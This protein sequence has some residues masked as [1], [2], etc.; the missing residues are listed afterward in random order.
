MSPARGRRW[1]QCRRTV[2]PSNSWISNDKGPVARVMV[3]EASL[4][5]MAG[6]TRTRNHRQRKLETLCVGLCCASGAPAASGSFL[7]GLVGLDPGRNVK[8]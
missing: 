2:R 5:W 1:S 4:P 3:L 6:H 8:P 7:K